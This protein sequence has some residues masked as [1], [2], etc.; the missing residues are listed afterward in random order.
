MPGISLAAA[1]AIVILSFRVR[2]SC[3]LRHRVADSVVDATAAA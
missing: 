3:D 2:W 1:D